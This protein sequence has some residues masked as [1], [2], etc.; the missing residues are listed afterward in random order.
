LDQSEWISQSLGFTISTFVLFGASTK[1][2][3]ITEDAELIAPILFAAQPE[4]IAT[5]V[6]ATIP[7]KSLFP[8]VFVFPPR[9]FWSNTK[10]VS[11]GASGNLSAELY[12][13]YDSY[14]RL[15]SA[16][17]GS[18]V[19]DEYVDIRM[20]DSIMSTGG[21]NTLTE[22]DYIQMW[23]ETSAVTINGIQS[24]ITAGA[25]KKFINHTGGAASQHTGDF[26]ITGEL[27]ADTLVAND[28]LTLNESLVKIVDGIMYSYDIVREKYLSVDRTM[29]YFG[30]NGGF[31]TNAWLSFQGTV[32]TGN[33]G[34]AFET[35]RDCTIVSVVVMAENVAAAVFDSE[36]RVG[37]TGAQ[38]GATGTTWQLPIQVRSS[39]AVDD[40]DI[41]VDVA[42]WISILTKAADTGSTVT[43]PCLQME[44]AWRTT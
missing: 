4:F 37:N 30:R 6:T 44:I 33:G 14:V 40:V 13:G 27:D 3:T 10:F 34:T 26:T 17:G 7:T 36:L 20:Y 42:K 16:A 21:T 43:D 5:N 9:N 28:S 25:T 31:T 8:P 23:D 2:T 15:T 22:R 1:F 32:T 29:I 11:S 24:L 35:I 19:I 39:L 41:D 12:I 18:C 38:P